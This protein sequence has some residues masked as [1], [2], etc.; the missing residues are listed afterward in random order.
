M[1]PVVLDEAPCGGDGCSRATQDGGDRRPVVRGRKLCTACCARLVEGLRELP[2]LH[3]ACG[4]ALGGDAAHGMK[5]KITGGPLPGLVFNSAAAE[6]RTEIVTTLASWSGLVADE[7]RLEAPERQ[8]QLLANFLLANLAWLAS[9]PAVVDLSVATARTVRLARQA[10][11]PDSVKR[12]VVGPCATPGCDGVLTA[13]VRA[14]RAGEG[15]QVRCGTNP[16]HTWDS[17]EWTRLR[18]EMRGPAAATEECW[19]TAA[20]IVRLWSTPTGTVY[21]LASEQRWR[22]ITRAGRTYYAEADV[23]SSFSRRQARALQK[24]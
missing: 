17:H 18:R 24:G 22:R 19:L 3:A 4:A 6:A 23:H 5:E 8:V 14:S 10:A 11:H 2:H 20:D 7:R 16:G 13:T 21:R 1:E 9:H 15:T 12:I